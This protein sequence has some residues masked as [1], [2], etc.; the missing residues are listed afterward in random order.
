MCAH[1]Q[2][3]AGPERLATPRAARAHAA[4]ARAASRAAPPLRCLTPLRAAGVQGAH[5]ACTMHAC[6]IHPMATR[7]VR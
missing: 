7:R 2:C 1:T 6:I 4:T 3:L 5:S